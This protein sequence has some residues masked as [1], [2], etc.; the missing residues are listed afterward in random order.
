MSGNHTR[1][2]LK[3]VEVE[4]NQELENAIVLHLLEMEKNALEMNKQTENAA[5]YHVVNQ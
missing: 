2:V 1:V 3:L 5:L 4:P